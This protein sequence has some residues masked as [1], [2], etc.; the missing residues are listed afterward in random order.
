M[1]RFRKK[2]AREP[3]DAAADVGREVGLIARHAETLDVRRVEHGQRA[4]AAVTSTRQ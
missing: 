1:G 3:A 2:N 4:G